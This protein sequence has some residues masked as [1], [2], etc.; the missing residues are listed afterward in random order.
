MRLIPLDLIIN[1]EIAKIFM[2][3]YIENDVEMTKFDSLTG[4]VISSRVQSMQ[5]PEEL[6]C[7]NH[8]FCDKTGT[9]TKNELEFRGIS[10]S[11]HLSKGNETKK[12]LEQVYINNSF[13]A[14][15][16]FKCFV[17]C[18]DV[19][20][21]EIKGKTVMSGTSQDELIVID[22]ARQSKYF[23]LEKRDSESIHLRDN[24]DNS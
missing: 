17:I 24:Q 8:V 19:I 13:T 7:I 21:M 2:S 3:R 12:I 5:L 23:S 22:V 14:E 1:T 16:L 20:P 15:M 18:H 6:G 10:F 11:G 9:L 4:D